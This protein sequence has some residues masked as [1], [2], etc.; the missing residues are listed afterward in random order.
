[1][2]RELE[3]MPVNIHIKWVPAHVNVPGNELADKEAKEARDMN[4]EPRCISY[5]TTKQLIRRNIRDPP[6]QHKLTRQVD[7]L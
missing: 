3:R 5:Q 6:T 1:M 4:E 7:E 2:K